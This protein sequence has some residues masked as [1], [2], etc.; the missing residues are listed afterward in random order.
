M[1]P[2]H[3]L[4]GLFRRRTELFQRSHCR[5]SVSDVIHTA[6]FGFGLKR[7]A[8]CRKLALAQPCYCLGCLLLTSAQNPQRL[9]SPPCA[10]HVSITTIRSRCVVE[11]PVRATAAVEISHKLGRQRVF[12]Y[13]E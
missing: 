7:E 4:F 12:W 1:K 11:T 8:A 3:T 10:H 9:Q 6:E 5:P 2:A 13:T